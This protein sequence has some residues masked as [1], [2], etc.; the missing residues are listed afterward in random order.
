MLKINELLTLQKKSE[1]NLNFIEGLIEKANQT[2]E[3]INSDKTRSEKWKEET[4]KH[5]RDQ[6][7]QPIAEKI[8]AIK[9]IAE[10]AAKNKPFW[11]SVPFLLSIQ[12]FN[13]EPEK[14]AQI[15]LAYI[16]ELK[17]MP[18]PL[19]DLALRN[20]IEEGNLPLI[21]Q[22]WK[23]GLSAVTQNNTKD[24]INLSLEGVV[25]PDQAEALEAI[26]NCL[27]IWTNVETHKDA[28]FGI[29]ISPL[30]RLQLAREMQ[31]ITRT[32]KAVDYLPKHS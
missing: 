27:K 17:N 7:S 24:M 1:I 12:S 3:D 30:K 15:R 29:T 20:A 21:F 8:Q 4:I 11:E 2:I 25:I 23:A 6:L 10:E 5:T 16:H 9:E 28:F 22:C 18:L 26:S 13:R 32:V 14:D 19:I 31:T